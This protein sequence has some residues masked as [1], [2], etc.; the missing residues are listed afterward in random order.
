VGNKRPPHMKK[1]QEAMKYL[2]MKMAL[3]GRNQKIVKAK[4]LNAEASVI[5]WI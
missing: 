3:F 5:L 2:T 4:Y 1:I